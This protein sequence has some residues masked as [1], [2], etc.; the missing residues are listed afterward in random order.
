MP[1]PTT[2]GVVPRKSFPSA[3]KQAIKMVT[4]CIA[5]KIWNNSRS[6]SLVAQRSNLNA[7]TLHRPFPSRILRLCQVTPSICSRPS[8]IK[9][10]TAQTLPKPC[11]CVGALLFTIVHASVN[12]IDEY[13]PWLTAVSSTCVTLASFLRAHI[14][15]RACRWK[16]RI[17]ALGH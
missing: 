17:P 6:R 5:C 15:S 7:P 2:V 16:R 13:F 8:E 14:S 11:C 10:D 9:P 3:L 12:S 1:C 4:C